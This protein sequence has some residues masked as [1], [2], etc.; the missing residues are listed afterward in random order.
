MISV[1]IVIFLSATEINTLVSHQNTL[2]KTNSNCNSSQGIYNVDL[3]QELSY[4][5]M[6]FFW[7]LKFHFHIIILSL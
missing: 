1:H 4:A 2:H 3:C 7:T 5:F 6:K